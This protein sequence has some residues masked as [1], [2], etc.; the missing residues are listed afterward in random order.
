MEE[1]KYL[2][3]YKYEIDKIFYEINKDFNASKKAELVPKFAFHYVF[4]PKNIKKCNVIIGIKY[5]KEENHPFLMNIVIRGFFEISEKSFLIN[6]FAILFPYLR[7]I[8]TDIT[9]ASLIPLVLPIINVQNLID[10]KL[11]Y[12][13]LENSK[14]RELIWKVGEILLFYMQKYLW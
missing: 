5:D 7:S 6:A 4:S 14:Y 11:E 2:K 8:I 1:N 9:K 10:K 13:E 3:F 12:F